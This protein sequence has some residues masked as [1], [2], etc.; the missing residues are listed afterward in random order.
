MVGSSCIR[1]DKR[2]HFPQTLQPHGQELSS[3]SA[4][5]SALPHRLHGDGSFGS[6]VSEMSNE[7]PSLS[8]ELESANAP[9]RQF[10]EL[11]EI[12][13]ISLGASAWPAALSPQKLH[14]GGDLLVGRK[15][16]RRLSSSKAISVLESISSML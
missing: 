8:Q 12:S 11:G 7:D 2:Q 4:G 15:C 14:E 9:P 10:R 3:I 5:A 13:E 6:V 1:S 16:P